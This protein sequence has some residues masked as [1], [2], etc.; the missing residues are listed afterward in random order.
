MTGKAISAV[1]AHAPWIWPLIRRP[2]TGFFDRA[3]SG[4]DERTGAGS[5]NHLAPLAA[6]VLDMEGVPESILDIG[7]GTGE[8]TLFLAREFPR[9]RV[10][11]VDVSAAMISR[12]GAK[13][14]LDPE[15]RV[16]FRQGD[17][18]SLPWPDDSFDLVTA[19][20]MP[21]FFTEIDRVL[22]PGGSVIVVATLGRDTPFHTPEQTV[23]RKFS[24]LGIER[25][26][27][28]SAGQGTW[29]T[30]TRKGGGK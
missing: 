14:G 23:E 26:G 18:S 7:C 6:G 25:S 11:G 29:F 21:L 22:R 9:A 20:N 27:G 17:S 15:A 1:V 4:W 12:A 24:R 13:I 5:L 16:A 10:R 19:V 30:A 28:G 3:A 8:A 2:V